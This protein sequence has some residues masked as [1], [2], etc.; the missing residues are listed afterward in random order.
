[1]SIGY[2]TTDRVLGLSKFARI[3]HLMAH[4]L[5]IQERMTE[6]IADAVVELTGSESVAVLCQGQHLCMTMRGVKTPA[7]MVTSEMRGLFRKKDEVRAEFLGL[8]RH[9]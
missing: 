3:V 2:I 8:A 7:I 1:V 9:G 4:R 6:Q 5:Q